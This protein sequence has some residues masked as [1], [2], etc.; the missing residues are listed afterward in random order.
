MAWAGGAYSWLPLSACLRSSWPILLL[1]ES[2]TE[3]GEPEPTANPD[4][5]FASRADKKRTS[6]V[7]ALLGPLFRSPA[8]WIVCA[9]SLGTT[10]V[11]ETFST[12]TPTYFYEVVGFSQAK[13]AQ[14]SA[15]FPLF[16]GYPTALWLSKRP[17]GTRG[18]AAITFA[19][20][21]CHARA[22]VLALLRPSALRDL[23]VALVALWGSS[24]SVHTPISPALWRWT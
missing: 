16:G 1:K 24:S 7:A 10:F 19:G 12:W 18:R 21:L 5:L 23:P 9:L 20:L 11:R 8:F 15:L 4:N 22:V 6:G 14:F 2:S 3:I 17:I 13:S